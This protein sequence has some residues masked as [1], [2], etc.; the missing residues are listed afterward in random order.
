MIFPKSAEEYMELQCNSSTLAY[1]ECHDAMMAEKFFKELRPKNV[2]EIG[3]G[4]GRV[5]VFLF[6][7][8]GWAKTNFYL[9]D[10]NSGHEQICHVHKYASRDHFYN[11]IVA[12]N[13]YCL[14]NNIPEKQLHLLDAENDD[15]LK[16]PIKFDLC[17]SF[18]AIGFHWPI[19]SYL[20]VIYPLLESGA[21]LIFEIRPSLGK[22]HPWGERYASFNEEQIRGIRKEQ[23]KIRELSAERRRSIVV[24]EKI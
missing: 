11:S 3:A 12:A 16:V 5:S 6:E 2:L 17:Y 13:E 24:L 19:T 9:L 7:K 8:F 15:W 20:D 18:K 14:A 10:G 21:C 1:T 23:Y 22:D 4:L